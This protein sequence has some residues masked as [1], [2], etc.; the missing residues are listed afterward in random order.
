MEITFINQFDVFDTNDTNVKQSLTFVSFVSF[1]GDYC[2][3]RQRT[4]FSE[5][6]TIRT[7]QYGV[8]PLS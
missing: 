3:I 1:D 8:R 5:N 6:Q 4:T 2:R 7:L